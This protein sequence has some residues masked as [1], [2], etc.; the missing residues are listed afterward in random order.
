MIRVLIADDHPFVRAGVAALLSAA[1]DIDL[2]AECEDGDEVV[3]VADDLDPDVILMDVDMPARSGFE[4]TSEL[5]SRHQALRVIILSVS[6]ETGGG[7]DI[8]AQAGAVGYMLKGNP[9]QLVEAVRRVAAGET[10]WPPDFTPV[11]G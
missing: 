2:V 4:A 9:G 6:L 10:A 3:R 11:P 8:A 7:P 5:M 1:D